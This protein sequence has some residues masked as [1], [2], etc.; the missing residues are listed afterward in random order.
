MVGGVHS[1]VDRDMY[2]LIELYIVI[3]S[4]KVA[5]SNSADTHEGLFHRYLKFFQCAA[6]LCKSCCTLNRM[7]IS[8]Y[9]IWANNL[10]QLLSRGVERLLDSCKA[11]SPRF[12]QQYWPLTE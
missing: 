10:L 7:M 11:H 5:V 6:P 4:L 3:I 1:L 12:I 8:N 2:D 9:A